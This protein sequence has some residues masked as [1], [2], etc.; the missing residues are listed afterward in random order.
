MIRTVR[1][2]GIIPFFR[3]GV[4]GWSIEELTDQ[5]FWFYTSDQLGPWDWK[6]EVV[7]EG[8]IAYGKFLGGKAAFATRDIYRHLMNWRRSL[9]KY[10][11][12]LGEDR[13]PKAK[14]NGDEASIYAPTFIKR[15]P[16]TNSE[17]L[18]RIIS[19]LALAA[20]REHGALES[21]E[22]RYLCGEALTDKQLN[23]FDDKYKS[24]L[25]PAVKKNVMDSVLQFLAMGTW[26]V[27]GDMTRVYRGANLEYTGWQRSSVTTPDA[28]FNTSGQSTDAPF[29]EKFIEGVDK[30]NDAIDCAPEESQE[31]LIEHVG[32]MF[33]DHIFD[34]A[35]ML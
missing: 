5:D 22:L 23:E 26:I 6:I 35:R 24:I 10:R 9:A 17:K 3:C 27:I 34:I 19:P 33:P 8:D 15:K 25:K 7:R 29:W 28:L 4:P 2:F 12:A 30:D 21:K 13:W 16:E 20:I 18:L 31:Y 32:R 11:V 1:E 14:K